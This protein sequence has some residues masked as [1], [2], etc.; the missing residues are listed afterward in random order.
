MILSAILFT[1]LLGAFIFR[2]LPRGLVWQR[3][4]SAGLFVLLIAVVYGGA[5][6]LLSRPK[7]LRLEWRDAATAKVLGASLRE[8]E[9]IYVWLQLDGTDEPRAYTLPWNMELAQQL[10]TAMSEAENT[11]TGVAMK[12]PF[13]SSLDK[14][15][16][17]F[18]A[19]PQPA[20]PEKNYGGSDTIIY[21]QPGS[22]T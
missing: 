11:G 7:P 9:G 19:L 17:K 21:Q 12:L 20:L 5:L 14:R 13:D 15:E 22:A 4:A 8:G 16:P 10:Q 2:V 18:Y 3:T 1:L 6:E